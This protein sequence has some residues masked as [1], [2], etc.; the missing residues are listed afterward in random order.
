MLRTLFGRP[1]TAATRPNV[2]NINPQQLHERLESGEPLILVD[3]RSPGE[4]QWDGH[5]AGARLLPLP[6]LSSRID[7]LPKDQTIVC[8]CRSGNRSQVACEMLLRAGF[9]DVVNL[10][11]GMIGWQRSRFETQ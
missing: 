8:V 7:E 5:I 11:Q 3:V 6:A 4:F 1:A 2:V 9:Q 10:S